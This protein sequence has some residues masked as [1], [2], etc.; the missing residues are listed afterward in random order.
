M[1]A[2]SDATRT[3]GRRRLTGG[4]GSRPR[5]VRATVAALLLSVAAPAWSASPYIYP[6]KGQTP[7]Q[8]ASD[9]GECQAWARQQTGFDPLAP[10]PSTAPSSG[11]GGPSALRGA[12]GGAAVGAAVGAIAGDAGKGAA[13]GAAGGGLIG[14]MRRHDQQQ[15]Q[16]QAQ[17]QA[18]QGYE[19]Q[20]SEFM[21]AYGACLQGRGYTVN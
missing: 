11:R 6:A 21:R 17:Q 8:Q 7:E 5:G 2:K 20:R 1:I 13:M 14:G 19:Q 3:V 10:P 12:A 18:N 15:T 4:P 16:Q 9:E